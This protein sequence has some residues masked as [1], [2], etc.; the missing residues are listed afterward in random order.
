VKLAGKVEADNC[1]VCE[2][3]FTSSEHE[4]HRTPV[5]TI[6]WGYAI[7]TDW[8]AKQVVC[9]GD[10]GTT[11][12]DSRGVRGWDRR[13][14]AYPPEVRCPDAAACGPAGGPVLMP[15]SLLSGPSACPFLV[16]GGAVTIHSCCGGTR[17]VL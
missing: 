14:D 2:V 17:C 11:M 3:I 12:G 4:M 16:S 9:G 7:V 15:L 1:D 6:R 10:C 8:G 13:S 5:S